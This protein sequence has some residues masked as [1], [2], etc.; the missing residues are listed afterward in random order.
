M[1][2]AVAFVLLLV[3]ERAA[4]QELNPPDP[5]IYRNLET[6]V[7][8]PLQ[9]RLESTFPDSFRR[10]VDIFWEPRD[11]WVSSG[12][13]DWWAARLTPGNLEGV[14]PEASQR[15]FVRLPGQFPVIS[16]REGR[17]ICAVV[18][19][20][21]NLLGSDYGRLI[22]AHNMVF[23]VNRAPTDDYETD[24]GDRTTY[25]V[26][27]PRDLEDGQFDRGAVLLMTPIATGV[28]DVFDRITWL[29]EHEFHWDPARVRIISPE[30]VQYLEEN[31]TDGE[32]SYP[33][34]GFIAMMVAMH[35]CDEVDLFGFGADANGRWDRYYEQVAEEV[36]VIH[37]VDFE[38]RLRREMEADGLL[39]VF[40]GN[41]PDPDSGGGPSPL[42]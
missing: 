27:W 3:P 37:P 10:G 12:V 19:A 8:G 33:S 2:A 35:V 36:S 32:N 34:T 29:V 25:H 42:D 38:V 30:F 13:F 40:Y 21:R 39:K 23:R 9:R 7:D 26:M 1:Y 6:S 41:R 20:S 4:V 15:M 24:V 22:D 11:G 31:W 18:G 28:D 16:N 5:Q 17:R 14:T